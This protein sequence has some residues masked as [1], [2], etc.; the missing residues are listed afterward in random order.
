MVFSDFCDL[1][2]LHNQFSLS[3]IHCL[4]IWFG[5]TAPVGPTRY[6][7]YKKIVR[8]FSISMCSS[9]RR[10]ASS[11]GSLG[12]LLLQHIQHERPQ[13]APARRAA[14]APATRHLRGERLLLWRRLSST[15]GK[16]STTAPAPAIGAA[17]SATGTST[18]T[19][20][21]YRAPPLR[22][23]PPSK[24]SPSFPHPPVSE[25][26]RL[27]LSHRNPLSPLG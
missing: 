13:A 18:R 22:S 20:G 10:Q 27:N 7:L 5:I 26:S 14:A 24:C 17:A 12:L 25:A 4:A 15:R 1:S 16:A 8:C 9:D 6:F 2:M 21:A 23:L 19:A 11:A 3:L